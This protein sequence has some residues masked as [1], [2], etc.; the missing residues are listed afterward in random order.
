MTFMARSQNSFI[1]K[2]LEKKKKKKR[3]E[4]EQ[5]KQQRQENSTGGGLDNMMAYV[6]EFGRITSTPPV[7][8]N[9]PVVKKENSAIGKKDTISD[10]KEKQ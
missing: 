1:K 4:K 10:K 6:D 5:R 8:K 7:P 9:E 3:E 2:E